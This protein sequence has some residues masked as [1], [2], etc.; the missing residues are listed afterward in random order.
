MKSR[1]VEMNL[2]IPRTGEAG[3]SI[4]ICMKGG[5]QPWPYN[6]FHENA[7]GR[8][9]KKHPQNREASNCLYLVD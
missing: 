6:Y 4:A 2:G 9:M 5:G 3:N 1:L 8:R 7:Y